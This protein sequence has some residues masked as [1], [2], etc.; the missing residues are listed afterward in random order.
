M[1]QDD[2]QFWMEAVALSA[3]RLDARELADDLPVILDSG[4]S[5]KAAAQACSVLIVT[6]NKTAC[7]S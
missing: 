5:R 7:A 3:A 6:R 1:A 4:G 2:P